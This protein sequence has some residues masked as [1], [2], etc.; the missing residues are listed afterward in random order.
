MGLSIDMRV[1]GN[2]VSEIAYAAAAE[3]LHL[4]YGA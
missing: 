1:N 4:S 2:I 3:P